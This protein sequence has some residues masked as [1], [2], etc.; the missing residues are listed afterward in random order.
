HTSPDPHAGRTA[1]AAGGASRAVWTAGAGG[2]TSARGTLDAGLVPGERGI[3]LA[4]GLLDE[5]GVCPLVHARVDHAVLRG[6]QRVPAAGEHRAC[7]DAD[8]EVGEFDV[9]RHRLSLW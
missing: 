2:P 9:K 8:S 3:A 4:A 7:D 1:S 6:R 5:Q